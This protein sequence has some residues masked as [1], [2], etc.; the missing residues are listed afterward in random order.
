MAAPGAHTVPLKITVS[1]G[2]LNFHTS[3]FLAASPYMPSRT[4]QNQSFLQMPQAQMP[5]L[6]HNACLAATDE[7]SATLEPVA[8]G[9][10]VSDGASAHTSALSA[11][12]SAST[13]VTSNAPSCKVAHPHGLCCTLKITPPQA[14]GFLNP[15]PAHVGMALMTWLR[16]GHINLQVPRQ[17]LYRT[18]TKGPSCLASAAGEASMA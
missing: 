6:N 9:G 4:E 11:A 1:R 5:F 12:S 17:N 18:R 13:S 7:G 16:S 2:S 8:P 10:S 14:T 15:C 3:T